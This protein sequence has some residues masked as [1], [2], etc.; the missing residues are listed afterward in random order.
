MNQEIQKLM[1]LVKRA[2][3]EARNDGSDLDKIIAGLA[4]EAALNV[5]EIN[6][7]VEWTNTLKQ[8][9]LFKAAED[10]TTEFHV[11]DAG[12]I[13]RI[14]YGEEITKESDYSAREKYLLPDMDLMKTAHVTQKPAPILPASEYPECSNEL[15][16][17]AYAE[18]DKAKHAV[19]EARV[20]K[21]SAEDKYYRALWKIA[22]NL[23][24]MYSEDFSEFEQAARDT[25]GNSILPHLNVLE[26][27]ATNNSQ[28]LLNYS[29]KN[30]INNSENL[31]LLK[32][33]M[34]HRKL[35]QTFDAIES[36]A[37]QAMNNFVRRLG[38][39]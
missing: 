10:K 20:E 4:K 14:I 36:H 34:V 13:R 39:E 12:N 18:V 28:R 27:M 2:I 26:K 38:H 35:Y 5:E 29:P 32:E 3:A 6:R 25:M 8:L 11:A 19:K 1:G 9:K 21:A 33:A 37:E 31:S 22:Q 24:K 16:K 17:L 23:N 15:F 30:V 7:V